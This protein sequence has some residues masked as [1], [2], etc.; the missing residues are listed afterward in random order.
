MPEDVI[1]TLTT[2]HYSI[3]ETVDRLQLNI[4]NYPKAKP[5][6]RELH[7]KLMAH[8]SHQNEPFFM[9]LQ[10]Q[11]GQARE[12]LK[13]LEFLQFDLK[14]IKVNLLVFFDRHSGEMDDI[15]FRSFPKDFTDLSGLIIGRIK[16][17]KDYLIPI[18]QKCN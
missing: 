16:M 9:A 18:L 17:E 4:R 5:L 12:S 10:A 1:R 3:L 13:M 14:E 11:C 6:I 8:F 15:H 2:A 7:Q